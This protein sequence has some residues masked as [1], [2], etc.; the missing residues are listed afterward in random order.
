MDA[1]R[2]CT[3]GERHGVGRGGQQ[4][5]GRRSARLRRR[6]HRLLL[7]LQLLLRGGARR[8]A[9]LRL[10]RGRPVPGLLRCRGGTLRFVAAVLPLLTAA[11]ARG[12]CAASFGARLAQDT[13]VLPAERRQR[14]PSGRLRDLRLLLLRRRPLPVLL[15]LS[16]ASEASGMRL[17]HAHSRRQSTAQLARELTRVVCRSA[18]L[19]A[20]AMAPAAHLAMSSSVT[21]FSTR[22]VTPAAAATA[23]QA[24]TASSSATFMLPV[25]LLVADAATAACAGASCCA[26]S[27]DA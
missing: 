17:Q 26:V 9:P 3:R 10:R 1:K 11:A 7:R 27:S 8:L 16:L 15:L 14:R 12:S 24:G 5:S 2:R 25:L 4:T 18:A 13:A 21:G 23:V 6:W 20:S 22:G 19:T